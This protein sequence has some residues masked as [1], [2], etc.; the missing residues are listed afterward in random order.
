MFDGT[1]YP[2]RRFV[3]YLPERDREGKE[4]PNMDFWVKEACFLLC[5]LNGGATHIK[6]QGV[7]YVA[8]TDQVVSE[9]VHII[10]T[11]IDPAKFLKEIALVRLFTE[12]FGRETNQD[13]VAVEFDNT[14]H[15]IKARQEPLRAVVN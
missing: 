9:P 12:R 15:L 8:E 2:I 7:W 3:L 14:L 6:A 11:A 4:V 13:A 1:A 10:Q 5:L